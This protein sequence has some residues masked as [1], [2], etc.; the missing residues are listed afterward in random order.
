MTTLRFLSPIRLLKR[1]QHQIHHKRETLVS[2]IF[3]E[4]QTPL[5]DMFA[6][7]SFHFYQTNHDAHASLELDGKSK[8]I[9]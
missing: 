6:G 4:R 1:D 9:T 8:C 5:S 2:G 3:G 7:E